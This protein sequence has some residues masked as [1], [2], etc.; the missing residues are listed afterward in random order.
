M[1][2]AYY[3]NFIAKQN[4]VPWPFPLASPAPNWPHLHPNQG[5][6][7]PIS[8]V[9][10]PLPPG[11]MGPHRGR[12]TWPHLCMI[13]CTGP[14]IWHK[15]HC[16]QN[17]VPLDSHWMIQGYIWFLSPWERSEMDSSHCGR[18]CLFTSIPDVYRCLV[19]LFFEVIFKW[20]FKRRYLD[21]E[22]KCMNGMGN[23]Y[24]CVS[25]SGISIL[26][27]EIYIENP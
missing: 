8:H 24:C 17:L 6:G 27:L 19:E 1:N 21:S 25:D 16:K 2:I 3:I 5:H 7:Q 22:Y 13:S 4:L 20:C 9:P 23:I 11:M 15:F 10:C 18:K 12:L 14:L 26:F